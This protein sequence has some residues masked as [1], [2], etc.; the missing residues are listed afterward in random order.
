MKILTCSALLALVALVSQAAS[1]AQGGAPKM[2]EVGKPAPAIRLNDHTGKIVTLGGPTK[3]WSILAFY[4]KAMTSG[5]TA[6]MCSMRDT[7]QDLVMVGADA[8]GISLDSVQEQ[9]QFAEKQKL[10]FP[11]LSDPDGS[12][13][14]KYGVLEPGAE[15]TKRVTFVIDDKGILRKI[16]DQVDV[17]KH[18]EDLAGMIDQMKNQQ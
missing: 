18:G 1:P 12:A 10:P 17:K 8:Y 14:T 9:A 2:P 13:A 16:I 11:L 3:N 6:E 4:P 5:C 7:L 15:Y